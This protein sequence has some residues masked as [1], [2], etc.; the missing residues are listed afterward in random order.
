VETR[1]ESCAS[2]LVH[3][4]HDA[5]GRGDA[6]AVGRFL[7]DGIDV[8]SRSANG[9]TALMWACNDTID[10]CIDVIRILLAHGADVNLRSNANIGRWRNGYTALHWCVCR[11]DATSLGALVASGADVTAENADGQTALQMLYDG[12]EFRPRDGLAGQLLECKQEMETI[13]GSKA[14]QTPAEMM[15]SGGGVAGRLQKE[16]RQKAEAAAAGGRRSSGDSSASGGSAAVSAVA[17]PPDQP[18]NEQV[19]GM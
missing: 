5:A 10:S 4:F 15:S 19:V 2:V 16:V 18:R 1:V 12:N 9:S 17:D 14:G 11:C 6:A 13:L 8:N 3:Q 7:Q